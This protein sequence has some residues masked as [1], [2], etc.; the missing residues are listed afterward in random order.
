MHHLDQLDLR[1]VDVC[2]EAPAFD[3]AAPFADAPLDLPLGVDPTF[4]FGEPFLAFFLPLPP[5]VA[6]RDAALFLDRA[7]PDSFF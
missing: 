4:G 1:V 7:R 6:F 3:L 2:E 5:P